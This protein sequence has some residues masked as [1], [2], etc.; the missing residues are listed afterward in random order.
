LRETYGKELKTY[1]RWAPAAARTQHVGNATFDRALSDGAI[2]LSREASALIDELQ[3]VTMQ[4]SQSS[5]SFHTTLNV[6]LEGRESDAVRILRNFAPRQ[7]TVLPMFDDLPSTASAAGFSREIS[8][9]LATK[10]MSILADLA[11]GSAELEGANGTF[12][13]RLA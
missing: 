7:G 12:A 13:K 6:D 8:D 2:E 1:L 3:R 5:G 4:V 11:Q 10:W 9:E